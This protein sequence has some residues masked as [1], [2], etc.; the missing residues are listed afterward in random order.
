[1]RESKFE[2][3]PGATVVVPTINRGG[4]LAPCLRDLLAQTYRPL[5]ILVVDQSETVPDEVRALAPAHPDV[6]SYY[7]VGF[8]GLPT[9]RNFGWQ[10]A[11]HER[12]VFV[13]DDIRCDAYL[14]A[15]HVRALAQPGIGAVAG[16][17]DE[18]NKVDVSGGR[19]GFFNRWTATPR[20]SF[21]E[22]GWVEV[23]HGPGGNFSVWREAV[24]QA[25]GLDE[26]MDI[27]AALYEE[28]DLFLR[29]GAAGYR[30]WFNGSARL[31]H[32]AAP[33]GGCRVDEV[34]RYVF[35]LAHNRSV[36]I[37]RHTRRYHRATAFGR[38]AL[39][40]SSYARAYRRP[41]ALFAALRGAR[42]G[43]AA[44]EH[45]P[46]CTTFERNAVEAR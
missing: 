31:T 35:S 20:R 16:G 34:E 25:G 13:D 26:A 45:A 24:R 9:A 32:L 22:E 44:G 27:G 36:L 11:R 18:A 17:I 5:E 42:E 29:I 38:L 4:F 1:M 15:E 41:G 33:S 37:R 8:R 40:A 6:I 14:V 28:T 46:V 12:I 21:C 43:Y 39:L 19:I 3:P 10:R 23:D 2:H 30:V 7:Q